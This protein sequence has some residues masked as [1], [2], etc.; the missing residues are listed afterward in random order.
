MKLTLQLK[1]LTNVHTIGS[2]VYFKF[3]CF[4]Q[5][6]SL[7]DGS[8]VLSLVASL[9]QLEWLKYLVLG[10]E[11]VVGSALINALLMVPSYLALCNSHLNMR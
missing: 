9:I 4:I 10:A 2:C 1:L 3:N 7:F 8:Y 6:I 5:L 11:L